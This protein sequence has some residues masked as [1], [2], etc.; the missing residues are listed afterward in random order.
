MRLVSWNV[1]GVRA[2]TRKGLFMPFLS[3][4]N[5]DVICLQE[6]K[7]Q[8]SQSELELPDYE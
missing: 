8:Q 1:N 4:L 2:V 3:G 7:A 5:P 6:T